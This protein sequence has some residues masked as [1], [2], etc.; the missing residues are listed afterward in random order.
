[1]DASQES[2]KKLPSYQLVLSTPIFILISNYISTLL[3]EYGHSFTAWFLGHKGNPLVLDYGG[4]SWINLLLLFK[5]DEYVD[6]SLVI[7]KGC[8]CHMAFIAFA[9][10]GMNGLLYIFSLFLLKKENIKNS[11]FVYYFGFWLNFINLA[12]LYS[13]IPIRTFSTRADI[14][15]LIKNSGISPWWIYIIFGYLVVFLI[16]CF[17]SKTLFRLF[18]DLNIENFS[19]RALIVITCVMI[20]FGYFGMAGFLGYGEISQFLSATSFALIPGMIWVCWP[21]RIEPRQESTIDG[22]LD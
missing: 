19:L 14:G 22:N 16:W 5:I 8:L 3:H 9:G 12:N 2:L 11:P 10:L 21:K 20:F 15:N 13:Y 17:F 7:A 18:I 6:Y 4:T 1:M